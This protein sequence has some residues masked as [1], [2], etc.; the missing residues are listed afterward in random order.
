M[1]PREMQIA[2]QDYFERSGVDLDITST[3]LFR[4]LNESQDDVVERYFTQFERDN[5]VTAVLEPLV[6]RKELQ[7]SGQ[8]VSSVANV[9]VDVVDLPADFRYLLGLAAKIEYVK[10]GYGSVTGTSPR[11]IDDG[12]K[13][14]LTRVCRLAQH[15][16][17]NRLMADPFTR[18]TWKEPLAVVADDKIRVYCD[19]EF[20]V[21]DI[22]L[23]YLKDPDTIAL[24]DPSG[25]PAAV[26][27]E[28]PEFLHR[29]IVDVAVERHLNRASTVRSTNNQPS[30]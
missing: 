30:S 9:V 3:E 15:D 18:S 12:D 17:I 1:S 8:G 2:F 25:S 21:S 22:V 7:P 24:A 11:V 14:S 6:D 16:D 23:D 28:L 26:S 4:E 5:V 10:G 13:I 27:S 29:E 20:V 19:T